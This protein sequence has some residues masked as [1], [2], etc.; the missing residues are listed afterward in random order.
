MTDKLMYV[1]VNLVPIRQ[2]RAAYS[3]VKGASISKDMVCAGEQGKDAC[4]V[5]CRYATITLSIGTER[6]EQTVKTKIR[7]HIASGFTKF[8]TRL[9]LF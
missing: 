9:A 4:Q 6:P 8:S 1:I 7:R 2:C 5:R 3:D